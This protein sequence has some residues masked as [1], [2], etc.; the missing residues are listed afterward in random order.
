MGHASREARGAS[1]LVIVVA[2]S[3]ATAGCLHDCPKPSSAAVSPPGSASQDTLKI[4]TW[5][6]WLMPPWTFQS[7][8][9]ARR[10]AAIGA[11]LLELDYDVLCLEKVFDER[12]RRALDQ[13]LSPR[14]PYRYGPVNC[15]GCLKQTSGVYVLSRLPLEEVR[16]IRYEACA[17]V[18]CFSRKGAVLLRGALRGRPFQ[19]LATH[20]QGGAEPDQLARMQPVREKQLRQVL[21]ELVTPFARPGEPLFICGDLLTPRFDELRPA[22]P[23]AGYS[24]LIRLFKAQNGPE[25]RITLDERPSVNDLGP[26]DGT[27]TG[28]LDYVLVVT[29]GV[30]LRLRWERHVLRRRGWDG[31]KNR[32]DLSYR[33]AVGIEAAFPP[34]ENPSRGGTP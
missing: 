27:R 28:E 34:A 17:G 3:L 33:Y 24:N 8:H 26:P 5:N 21:D 31:S 14:Y 10:A 1:L 20:L 11:A 19:I 23:S 18:D 16:E 29:R 7:P 15:R 30:D 32:Q 25:T 4:L 22:E 13:A 2:G 12:G 9:N 6:V